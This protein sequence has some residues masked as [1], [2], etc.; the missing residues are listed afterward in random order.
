MR[1]TPIHVL[2]ASLSVAH[3]GIFPRNFFTPGGS[4]DPAKVE[5]PPAK[6]AAAG[7]TITE[8]VRHTVTV[9]GEG[10]RGD[11]NMTAVHT[12]TV[13]APAAACAPSEVVV[14]PHDPNYDA[15]KF[16]G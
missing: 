6:D 3:A 7:K 12:V 4:D 15:K 13:E 1:L 8:T 10:A 14:D 11:M 9:N 2:A 5:H 16:E